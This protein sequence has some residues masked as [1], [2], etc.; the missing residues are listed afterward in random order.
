MSASAATKPDL[1][2]LIPDEAAE[3]WGDPDK[4]V[5]EDVAGVEVEKCVGARESILANRLENVLAEFVRRHRLGETFV[6][7]EVVLP[8]VRL[9]RKPDAC[10]ISTDTWHAGRALP[11]DT[12]A[13][14]APDLAVESV[15]RTERTVVTQAKVQ[16]YFAG[17]VKAVWLI[18]PDL[19]MVHC[20]DAPTRVRILAAADTL[21]G[22]PVV[23]G[24][25]LPL[26]DL[27]P[28]AD[29]LPA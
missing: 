7:L 24:F 29:P 5:V 27:F 4:R 15:S 13:S 2:R 17:G 1:T 21:T 25:A 23:P 26:A 14:V 19:R 16:E 12:W 20:Y 18:F 8:G 9:R 6:G 10:F 11:D 22:G 28:P 3:V